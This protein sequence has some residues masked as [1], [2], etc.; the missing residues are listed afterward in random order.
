M[1][2][3]T[4]MLSLKYAK[5]TDANTFSNTPGTLRIIEPEDAAAF[6]PSEVQ[7]LERKLASP[8]N[9]RFPHRPGPK[10]LDVRSLKMRLRGVNNNDGGALVAQSATEHGEMWDTFFGA[11]ATVPSG[12][13]T[14][15]TGGNGATPNVTVTS[16]AGF[17]N[18]DGILFATSASAPFGYI[19]REVVS[20][21]GT[22]TLVV[23]RTF[24]GTPVG[25]A[26]RAVRHVLSRSTHKHV[27]GF[28]SAEG[29][30]W[31][32][33]YFGCIAES[34]ELD[35]KEGDVVRCT[36][37]WR[38]M[39]WGEV[40]EANPAYV[41]AT[42]GAEILAIN[43]A[44]YLGSTEYLVKGLK[45]NAQNVVAPRDCVNGVNG[46]HGYEIVDKDEVLL[47]GQIYVGD[48]GGSIGELVYDAGSPTVK[49]L[50]SPTSAPA[51][52]FDVAIELANGGP[53]Q[54]LYIRMPALDL[55]GEIKD[56]NGLAVFD[57]QG[58]ACEP[59]SGSPLRVHQY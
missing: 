51:P 30:N 1:T 27:H 12:A 48:N 58:Y 22:T 21:G 7:R 18:G 4:R 16:G 40:D 53:G 24:S 8:D 14:T 29:E 50:Q 33:D 38:P 35:M 34:L 42:A 26:Y 15:V 56:S 54:S 59:S 25:T 10:K 23:D 20:G 43:S 5:H 3:V 31:R 9:R 39:D 28:F 44:F 46:V 19:A 36:M 32:C 47:T 13:A 52:T 6:Y 57:F 37:G 55:R 49:A 41:G 11:N 17:A 2:D 45:L